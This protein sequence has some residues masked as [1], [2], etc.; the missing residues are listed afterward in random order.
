M[1]YRYLFFALLVTNMY[2]ELG[3]KAFSFSSLIKRSEIIVSGSVTDVIKNQTQYRILFSIDE[4]ITNNCN[5]Q[6]IEIAVPVAN[7]FY[8]PDE[9][10]LEIGQEYLLFLHSDSSYWSICNKVGVFLRLIQVPMS[11]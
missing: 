9:S 5:E 11:V 2:A 4:C 3:P 6:S 8:I 1:K 10:Y 7:G